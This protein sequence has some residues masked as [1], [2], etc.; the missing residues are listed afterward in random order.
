MSELIISGISLVFFIIGFF[1]GRTFNSRLSRMDN[2]ELKRCIERSGRLEVVENHKNELLKEKEALEKK[3][4]QKDNLI[5]EQQ[6][7]IHNFENERIRIT[8]Q[9]KTTEEKLNFIAQAKDD[10]IAKSTTIFKGLASDILKNHSEAFKETNQGQI[11][12]I[13]SPLENEIKNYQIA[14]KEFYKA[15]DEKQN[16]LHRAIDENLKMNQNLA[17]EAAELTT[18]LQ[19]KKIQGNWGEMVLERVLEC[20]GL[21]ED[22]EYS[23]QEL[24]K[25]AENK[26]RYPDFVITLPQDRKVI[27]DS[28]ISIENYKRW[29]NENAP[30]QK[31]LFL[32]QHIQDIKRHIDELSNKEYQTLL[33]DNGLD[34]VIMFI[35]IE[36]A[37]Y[38]A[39]ETDMSLNEYASQRKVALATASSLFPILK[40]VENLWRIDTSNKNNEAIIKTGED[41]HKRVVAFLDAMQRIQNNLK[42]AQDSYNDAITKLN[43]NQGIIKSAIKL[44]ELGIKH[45]RTIQDISKK[46]TEIEI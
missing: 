44:E 34:F 40:V 14:I 11:L 31:K 22:R 7:L 26:R 16:F 28:K 15:Q 1:I 41:M 38:V 13:L 24:Y 3:V 21:K 37:Y 42:N 46:L 35:P 17:K 30:E 4:V 2:A 23:K 5:A 20:A 19:N 6:E 10:F 32:T 8:E 39:L 27:I 29:A 18:A 25:N 33:K 45:Q 12:Q 43:G 36:Y 9:Q